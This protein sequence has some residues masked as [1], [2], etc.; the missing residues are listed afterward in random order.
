MDHKEITQ[1]DSFPLLMAVTTQKHN[2]ETWKVCCHLT[3]KA[4]IA[5]RFSNGG[6]RGLYTCNEMTQAESFALIT[7]SGDNKKHNLET[8]TARCHPITGSTW[9]RIIISNLGVI[10]NES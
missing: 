9:T 4:F 2:L 8:Q 3:G 5:S 6:N 1:A 10:F 7:Y